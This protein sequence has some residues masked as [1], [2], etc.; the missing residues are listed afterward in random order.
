[1]PEG[2]V[3]LHGYPARHSKFKMLDHFRAAGAIEADFEAI[4][5]CIFLSSISSLLYY[6]PI[7]HIIFRFPHS[8]SP[9]L[10]DNLFIGDTF[11][12]LPV[13]ISHKKS[14]AMHCL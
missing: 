13:F 1:M 4:H 3:G 12:I 2:L 5:T 11:C 10:L 9:F 7:H 8:S 14:S 6:Q